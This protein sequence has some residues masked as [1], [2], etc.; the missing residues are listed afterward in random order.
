MAQVRN[1]QTHHY[2]LR[3]NCAKQ[4]CRD[5]VEEKL[6]MIQQA[7]LVAKVAYSAMEC[8]RQRD[9]SNTC[10]KI[11]LEC[12]VHVWVSGMTD[13]WNEVSKGSQN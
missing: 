3:H 8:I 1:K 11:H 12:C 5:A 13:M 10:E 6:I 4:L 7:I 9:A 2:R